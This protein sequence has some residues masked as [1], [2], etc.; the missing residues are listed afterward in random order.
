MKPRLSR[1]PVLFLVGAVMLPVFDMFHTHSG[2]TAYPHPVFLGMAWWT[3]LLF[4]ASLGFGGTLYAMG[5]RAM[6]GDP[7]I[8]PSSFI[9]IALVIYAGL[10]CA[11]GYLPVSNEGKLVVLLL[12]FAGLWWMLD[13]SWQGMALAAIAG[14]GGP[15]T[16]YFLTQH[17]CFQHLQPDFAGL[18][19]WLPGLYLASAPA[20]GHFSRRVLFA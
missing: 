6:K 3:P 17:G 8:P 4:S 12:G 9:A 10:Y 15:L 19:I 1:V 20:L 5:H 11:S 14:I 2:T 16:E 13:R 7:E 18:P